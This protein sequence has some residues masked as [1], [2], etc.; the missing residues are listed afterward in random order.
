M[1]I[2]CI[3]IKILEKTHHVLILKFYNELIQ[4]TTKI[5]NTKCYRAAKLTYLHIVCF[6]DE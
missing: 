2:S 3:Q 5:N 6:Q 4:F 1:I